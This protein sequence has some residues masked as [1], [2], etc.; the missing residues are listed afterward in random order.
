MRSL[1]DSTERIEFKIPEWALTY[2][3]NADSSNL[4]ED[5]VEK[6][7]N[8]VQDNHIVVTACPNETDGYFSHT[9]DIDNLGST[10]YDLDCL[11]SIKD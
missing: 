7:D 9:N 11:C 1:A 5:E 3:I 10:V 6:I 4:T 2:L 8:F